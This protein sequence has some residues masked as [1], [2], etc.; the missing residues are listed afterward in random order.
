MI[1]NNTKEL[2]GNKYLPA[3]FMNMNIEKLDEINPIAIKFHFQSV[4]KNGNKRIILPF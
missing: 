3:C 1:I 4:V 2:F